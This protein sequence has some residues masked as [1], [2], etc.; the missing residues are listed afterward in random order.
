MRRLREA[1]AVADLIDRLVSVLVAPLLESIA[2]GAKM[3]N[4]VLQQRRHQLDGV[5][6]AHDRLYPVD[7]LMDPSGYGERASIRRRQDRQPAQPQ[8]Q[9][10]GGRQL[11]LRHGVQN[12]GIDISLVETIEKYETLRAD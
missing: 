11:Q 2:H 12:I 6:T 1:H 4:A 5:G 8:Q 3:S 9:L 10:V 7:R